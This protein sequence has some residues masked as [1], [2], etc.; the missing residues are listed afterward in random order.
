[1]SLHVLDTDILSLLQRRHP[2]VVRAVSALSPDQL[3]ITVITVEEQLTGWYSLIRKARTRAQTAFAY[4]RL[5]ATA[6]GLSGLRILPLSEPAIDRYDALL[7]LRLGVRK[8]DLRI[9]AI[10]LEH[11]GILAT[12]N[13]RDFT[14][15]PGLPVV[16]WVP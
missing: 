1:M 14:R 3:A 4:D 10:V 2:D 7:A 6:Q 8:P 11:G 12:R 16:N 15:V 5:A 9:A 13:L